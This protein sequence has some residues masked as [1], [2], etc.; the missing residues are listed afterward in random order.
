MYIKSKQVPLPLCITAF[1]S[2]VQS[3]TVSLGGLEQSWVQSLNHMFGAGTCAKG[4]IVTSHL[5]TAP[6]S[7]NTIIILNCHVP[8]DLFS[9]SS[10]EMRLQFA[11]G[12]STI[13]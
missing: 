11:L 12:V 2:L 5:A 9:V 1:F 13:F 4:N 3:T 10:V 7:N 8:I 6:S